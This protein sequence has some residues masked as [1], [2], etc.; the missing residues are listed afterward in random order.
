[1][2]ENEMWALVEKYRREGKEKRAQNLTNLIEGLKKEV[3]RWK[4]REGKEKTKDKN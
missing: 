2:D 4:E 3:N 1:M